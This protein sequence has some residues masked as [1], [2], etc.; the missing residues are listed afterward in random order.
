MKIKY[1]VYALLIIGIIGFIGYRINSNSN[2]NADSKDQKG[3]SQAM[4]LSGIVVKYETFDNNLSLSGSIEA[5]E[6]VEIRSE[7]SGI[8]E[9]IYF[10][11]G[12]NVSK[13]QVLFKV[14]DIELK[15]QLRQTTTREGLA[16]ENERRAKLL[17]EKEAI[18]QE[19]YDVARA[20]FKSAQAQSQL[21]EAQIAKTSVRAPFS[22]KIGLRSISPGTYITPMILVAKLVNIGKLKITFS[23]PEKY[24]SQVKT[25][26]TLT[27]KVAGSDNKYSATVYAIDPEIAVATRTLQVRAIAEN[28]DGKLLPGTFADVELPLDIIK[29]AIVIPTEAIVPI[30]NGKKVFITNNGLAKELM[31]ETATRTET[32]VLVLSGLKEG[33]TVITNGVMSL[34][35]DDKVKVT[36][37]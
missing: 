11:E 4:A 22:G 19:E 14:N 13:G 32:S 36:I 6:Q 25:N 3:K 34:K 10:K 31:I 24:A 9:G 2:K 29:D 26:T 27:F 28:K 30:Q 33:D 5:N 12:S 37:K 23:I 1:V 7:V 8:V 21:I 16:F 18:S 35:N 17:L 15:A 20:D